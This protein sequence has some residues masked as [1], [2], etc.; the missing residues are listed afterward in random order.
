[1]SEG[2]FQAS[3]ELL[4]ANQISRHGRAIALMKVSEEDLKT[5]NLPLGVQGK[6]VIY[7]DQFTH[8]AVMRKVLLRMLGWL[9]YVFPVK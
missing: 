6:M 7:S 1:M 5:Y 9:N 2:Q 4:S 8:V 3:G